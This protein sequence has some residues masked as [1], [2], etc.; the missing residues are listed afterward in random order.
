MS[1]V[2]P[3]SFSF[4]IA[5]VD[6]VNFK[7]DRRSVARRFP[8]RMTTDADCRRPKIVLNPRAFHGGR[9]GFQL[10]CFLIK[11]SG[12]LGV[13]NGDGNKCDFFNHTQGS[14]SF[15]GFNL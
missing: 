12:A 7:R 6:I 9:R 5:R 13:R 10:E 4:A 2:T 8:R 11:L 15:S 3:R 1:N 14:F